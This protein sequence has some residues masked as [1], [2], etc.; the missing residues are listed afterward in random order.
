MNNARRVLEV[1]LFTGFGSLGMAE[2]LPEDGTVVTCEIQPYFQ[3]LA[4][5]NVDRSPHGKKITIKLGVCVCACVCVI[6]APVH[7]QKQT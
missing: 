5:K 1:G 2:A 7:V 4:R 6:N 3:E